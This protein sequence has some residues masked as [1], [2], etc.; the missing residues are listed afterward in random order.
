MLADGREDP[1]HGPQGDGDE[2]QIG[3]GHRVGRVL[4]EA[5]DHPQFDRPFQIGQGAPAADHLAHRPGGRRARA[6][7]PPMRPTPMTVSRWIMVMGRGFEHSSCSQ[8]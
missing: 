1:A 3:A 4:V 7:E 5:V 2:D 6:R 8:K